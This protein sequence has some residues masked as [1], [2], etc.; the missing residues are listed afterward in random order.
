MLTQQAI[1]PT[2][3]SNCCI[4]STCFA[5]QEWTQVSQKLKRDILGNDLHAMV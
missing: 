3:F 5:Q 1:S 2:Q 4:P